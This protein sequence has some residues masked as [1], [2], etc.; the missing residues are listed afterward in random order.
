MNALIRAGFL[1][2]V[3][4]G[5]IVGTQD[6]QVF[7]GF[8][9]VLLYSAPA[10]Q[11]P[12][13]VESELI[14]T[15]DG[16]HIES[17]FVDAA[18]DAGYRGIVFHGNGGNLA[19]FLPYQRWLADIG[20]PAFSFDYRGYGR[21][22]GWPS[23]EGFRRDAEAVWQH[24]R[25]RGAKP[26]R[27]VIVGVSLG[28]SP[29]AELARRFPPA[30]LVLFSPFVDLPSVVRENTPFRL[31]AP[32]V[33]NRFPTVSDVAAANPRCLLVAHGDEDRI[34]PPSHGRRVFEAATRAGTRKFLNAADA[35]HNDLF[36]HV[37][38]KLTAELQACLKAPS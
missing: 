37:R 14:E 12:S 36:H 16:E 17:W 34:V 4:L 28:C 9:Q 22:T 6:L 32:F 21:S 7:P 24:A 18:N 35:G 2:I 38:A 13:D 27:L 3:F 8:T 15:A 30:A 11:P 33:W 23:E 10:P 31:L 1:L 29:A 26:S 19:S 20:I 5:A 25:A